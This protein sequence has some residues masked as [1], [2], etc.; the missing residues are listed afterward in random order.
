MASPKLPE[1]DEGHFY[2]QGSPSDPDMRYQYRRWECPFCDGGRLVDR[3]RDLGIAACCGGCGYY[4]HQDDE[5]QDARVKAERARERYERE[6]HEQKVKAEAAA[7]R[8]RR[9]LK[10]Q[11]RMAA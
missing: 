8:L 5:L 7:Q 1:P 3:S 6:A 9:S 4:T 2:L 10:R 11:R